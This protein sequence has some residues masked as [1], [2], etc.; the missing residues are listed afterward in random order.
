MKR[1]EDMNI[2][3]KRV[4][5][6][7]DFNVPIENGI[8][9][10]D[11]RIVNALK[12]INYAIEKASKVIILS[13]LGRIKTEEDKQNNSLKIVCDRL[14][15]LLNK[16]VTFV[17]YDEDVNKVV[18]D[19]DLILFENVRYFDLDNKKESNEDPE[20]SKYFASF[21]DIFIN[22]GFGVSHRECA[23]LTGISKILPSCNGFLVCNEVD[24]LS[25]LLDGYEKPYTVCMGGKK[26]SDKIELIDSLITKCDYMLISGLMVYTFLA[27]KGYK[28]GKAF[29]EEDSFEYCKSLLEKYPEKIVLIKDAYVRND[30]KKYRLINEID[31]NDECLDI[32]PET[33]ET[34]KSYL[35][36]SKTIFINGPVGLFED[37]EYEYGSKSLCEI[38][39]NLDSKIYAGGGE[40]TYM[41]NKYGVDNAF[42]S[43][44]GGATLTF[45]SSGTLI[46]IIK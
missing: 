36:K 11:T 17:T 26:V 21:G 33:I 28:T 43:T 1:L 19:N 39:K 6:R 12:T 4:I 44:G 27:S 30:G 18:N 15:E 2:E 13:H 45:L 14:S 22:E 8:I 3:G 32:G 29:V 24:N 20:L 38:L 31:D 41:F 9:K 10:D 7:C 42:K 37:P 16:K 40:T 34:F 35:E 25:N 23:S 5:I 46:G